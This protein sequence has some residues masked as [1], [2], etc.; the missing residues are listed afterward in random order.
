M[1]KIIIAFLL[2]A[3]IILKAHW[4]DEQYMIDN[5]LTTEQIAQVVEQ[6]KNTK[7]PDHYIKR[8]TAIQA[9]EQ[10]R[11]FVDWHTKYLAGRLKKWMEYK[12]FE[13]QLIDRT[14]A[15]NKYRYKN[16]TTQDWIDRSKY[17][18]TE[19]DW[20]PNCPNWNKNVWHIV[21]T[22]N[23]SKDE[24]TPLV[25]KWSPKG[26]EIKTICREQTIEVQEWEY[27]KISYLKKA[28]IR[29]KGLRKGDTIQVCRDLS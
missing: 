10:G 2:W 13:I 4:Y 16:N 25:Q 24:R 17:C 11:T 5:W 1:K 29:I 8:F 9:H 19:N 26:I 27:L 28:R 23:S 15:Y 14:I 18:V 7:D 6:S 12:I 20:T 21:S 3:S 22:Y